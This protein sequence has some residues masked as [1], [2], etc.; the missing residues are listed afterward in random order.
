MKNSELVIAEFIVGITAL[1]LGALIVLVLEAGDKPTVLHSTASILDKRMAVERLQTYSD[2][3]GFEAVFSLNP[4]NSSTLHMTG[5][6]LCGEDFPSLVSPVMWKLVVDAGF[7]QFHCTY[8][9]IDIQIPVS[10]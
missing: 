4:Q 1:I 5:T 6:S 2:Y 3:V 10:K 9:S 7:K 8:G